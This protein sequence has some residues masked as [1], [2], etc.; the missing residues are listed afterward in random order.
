VFSSGKSF[1]G[2]IF[3]SPSISRLATFSSQIGTPCLIPHSESKN[4]FSE[5]A[6]AYVSK[7]LNEQPLLSGDKNMKMLKILDD[8][9]L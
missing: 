3:V 9:L 8:K 1:R 4:T 5:C 7:H 6:C 2:D